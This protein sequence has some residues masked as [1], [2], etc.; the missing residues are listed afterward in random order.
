MNLCRLAAVL[1]VVSSAGCLEIEVKM[2]E[3]HLQSA[4]ANP[5]PAIQPVS[6][7]QVTADNARDMAQALWDEFDREETQGA[8]PQR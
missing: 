4:P 5:P 7:D 1:A 3:P 2:R 8:A 6:A